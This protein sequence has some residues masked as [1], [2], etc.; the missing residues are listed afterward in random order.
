MGDLNHCKYLTDW[1]KLERVHGPSN[2]EP[3]PETE[4]GIKLSR[5]VLTCCWDS[6]VTVLSAALAD[7]P[8]STLETLGGKASRLGLLIPRRARKIQGKKKTRDNLIASSLDG[9]HK[10]TIC[11]KP[12]D[13]EI[14]IFVF[15][16]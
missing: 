8:I 1:Q 9:L 2:L 5:R 6:M 7:V 15:K 11:N 4:A 12:Q 3:S 14:Y 10:V 16:F 13:L